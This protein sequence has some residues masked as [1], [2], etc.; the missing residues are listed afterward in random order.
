MILPAPDVKPSVG[1]RG[2]RWLPSLVTTLG[3]FENR[4]I[5]RPVMATAAPLSVVATA[6]PARRTAAPSRPHPPPARG[7]FQS[8]LF[9]FDFAVKRGLTTDL[10]ITV[11][12]AF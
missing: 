5:C 7:I 4:H 11:G 9:L 1:F 6:L 10:S 12:L 2:L 8:A 3:L